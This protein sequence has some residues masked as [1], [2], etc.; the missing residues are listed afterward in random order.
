MEKK[1][2]YC[3]T[4][5][6]RVPTNTQQDAC[7]FHSTANHIHIIHNPEEEYCYAYTD[8]P[9]MESCDI[10]RAN[11]NKI[12]GIIIYDKGN[13]EILCATCYTKLNTCK[14]CGDSRSCDFITNPIPISQ[15]TMKTFRQGNSVIQTMIQNPDRI[16]ETCE[17]N[18]RCWDHEHSYCRKEVDDWCPHYNR[19]RQH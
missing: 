5:G 6:N 12:D 11:V 3:A 13:V 19:D 7:V 14:T 8:T 10:C 17:K 16:A 2:K 9:K 15:Q 18:C 4:C 1:I